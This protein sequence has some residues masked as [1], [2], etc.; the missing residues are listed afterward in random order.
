MAVLQTTN[1]ADLL[2]CSNQFLLAMPGLTG[3]Y[4][5]A[6]LIYV[7]EHNEDGALGLVVNRPSGLTLIEL[8][9]QIGLNT[10]P[11]FVD[12]P[13][14]SGGP[15]S[16]EQG[17]V[18]H[19][20]DYTTDASTAL[21]DE[22]FMSTAIDTLRAISEGRGPEQ[23]VITLGYAGWAAG[24]LEDEIARNVWLTAPS[25]TSVLFDRPCADRLNAAA[26]VLGIDFSLIAGRPGHA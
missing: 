23:Y 10:K 2:N 6:S 26:S 3:D 13:V 17:F 7:C 4:F 16:T 14:L 8:F 1:E 20:A 25:D 12:I 21:T 24:Q 18:L 5:A 15:V 19:S 9:A 22:L 11:A